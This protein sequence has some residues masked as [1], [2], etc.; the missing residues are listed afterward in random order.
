[1]E[2]LAEEGE[3]DGE[4]DDLSIYDPKYARTYNN[5]NINLAF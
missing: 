4:D 2:T 5:N 3:G 1:M